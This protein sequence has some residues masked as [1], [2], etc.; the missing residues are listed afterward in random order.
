MAVV[1][2]SR[3]RVVA[4]AWSRGRVVGWS[5]DCCAIDRIGSDRI[6]RLFCRRTA[7]TPRAASP[8]RT[9]GRGPLVAA[10]KRGHTSKEEQ[11]APS[12]KARSASLRAVTW[13]FAPSLVPLRT[14]CA[15]SSP[16]GAA[17][18]GSLEIWRQRKRAIRSI[19]SGLADEPTHAWIQRRYVPANAFA[20]SSS[21]ARS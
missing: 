4:V 3:G 13:K 6:G 16:R 1:A 14:A 2:W 15:R 9:F 18:R 12:S 8:R 10:L 21:D 20:S 17:A 19:R 5:R 7:K 11:I